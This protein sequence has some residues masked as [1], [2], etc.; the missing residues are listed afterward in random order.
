MD[1]E[2]R[3]KAVYQRIATSEDAV[4]GSQLAKEFKVSRQVIVQDI[5]LL[6]ARNYKI[7]ATHRGYIVDEKRVYRIFAVCHDE[8]MME[9][10]MNAIV[11]CGGC[12]EDVFVNHD[13]YGKLH[14]DMHIYSRKQVKDFIHEMQGKSSLP[15]SNLTHGFHYHT[16]SANSEQELDLIQEALAELNILQEA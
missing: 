2:S 8:K 1:K 11:D 16:I 14:A 9:E 12:I 3:I 4:S 7:Q 5:A 13:S 10:E 6:K 15:L